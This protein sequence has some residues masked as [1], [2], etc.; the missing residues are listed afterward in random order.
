VIWAELQVLPKNQAKNIIEVAVLVE[1]H[2][3]ER[4]AIVTVEVE[5]RIDKIKRSKK[6]IEKNLEKIVINF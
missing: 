2:L 4:V 3:K 1:A 6:L 5:A